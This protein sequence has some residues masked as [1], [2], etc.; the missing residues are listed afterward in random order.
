MN[1][2]L[3]TFSH[4]EDGATAAIIALLLTVLLGFTAAALDMSYANATRTK[5]QVTASAAALSGVKRIEDGEDN[6]DGNGRPDNDNRRKT[7]VMLILG[8]FDVFPPFLVPG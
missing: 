3:K 2:F 7:A 1:S 4:E 8:S 5:L 6:G